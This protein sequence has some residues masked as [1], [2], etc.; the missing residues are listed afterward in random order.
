M[1]G[2]TP[3]PGDIVA[4]TVGADQ[5][6]LLVLLLSTTLASG[7]LQAVSAQTAEIT[8]TCRDGTTWS[9][10]SRRGACSGHQGVQAF[11]SQAPALGTVPSAPAPAAR[12]STPPST[13]TP[14]ATTSPATPAGRD[15][16]PQTAGAGPSGVG[17]VWVNVDSKVYH[18]PGTRYYGK[19]SHGNYMTE[20][21]AKAEG[22]RP[23]RGKT[24]S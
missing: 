11:G 22:D 14:A 17:Q 21:A 12:S 24:C 15:T 3:P 4:H 1:S 16:R 13:T 8:A 19:T 7:M 10:T 20:A 23:S 5:V 18:C 2:Q 9:G 6:R